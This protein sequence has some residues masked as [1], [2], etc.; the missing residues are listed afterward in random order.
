MLDINLIPSVD[1]VAL[2]TEKDDDEKDTITVI[3]QTAMQ[4][5]FVGFKFFFYKIDIDRYYWIITQKLQ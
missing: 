4:E 3:K 2:D 5:F 1:W